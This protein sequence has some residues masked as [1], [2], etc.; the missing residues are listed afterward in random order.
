MLWLSPAE[1]LLLQE[2]H[3]ALLLRASMSEM[4]APDTWFFPPLRPVFVLSPQGPK[5][6]PFPGPVRTRLLTQPSPRG[7]LCVLQPHGTLCTPEEDRRD[8]RS[9]GQGSSP[10]RALVPWFGFGLPP[11]GSCVEG[12][13]PRAAG[14]RGGALGSDWVRRALAD[15]WMR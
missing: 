10:G 14:L 11:K 13:V 12:L 3:P 5:C 2:A 6:P 1:G 8:H 7:S 9:P 15:P 4:A